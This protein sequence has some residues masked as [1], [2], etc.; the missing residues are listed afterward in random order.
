MGNSGKRSCIIRLMHNQ[1]FHFNV[2]WRKSFLLP[3][4]L[5]H[6][7]RVLAE[8]TEDD[9]TVVKRACFR[10]ALSQ[11][12]STGSCAVTQCLQHHAVLSREG[13]QRQCQIPAVTA[14]KFSS[15]A[16]KI[17]F[18][19]SHRIHYALFLRRSLQIV[20]YCLLYPQEKGHCFPIL[21]KTP[22]FDKALLQ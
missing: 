4:T 15:R 5:S 20:F 18:F 16:P 2:T 7:K 17:F 12:T 13:W 19:L 1:P 11:H 22:T 10:V 3:W 9:R 8:D 6:L 21:R 14:L